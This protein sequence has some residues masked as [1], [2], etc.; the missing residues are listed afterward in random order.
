VEEEELSFGQPAKRLKPSPVSKPVVVE[1]ASHPNGDRSHLGSTSGLPEPTSDSEEDWDEV[2]APSPQ[3]I[4]IDGNNSDVDDTGAPEEIDMNAFEAE[5]I[6]QLR[7]E[8]DE[9]S[10]I[11]SPDPDARQPISLNQ[12]ASREVGDASPVEEEYSSSDETD[13]D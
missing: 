2:A 12:F 10:V 8:S 1:S 6:Q 9:E 13:E 7:R 3:N 5:M 4:I 11:A